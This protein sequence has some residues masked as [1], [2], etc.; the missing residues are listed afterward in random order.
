[1]V[2]WLF[3]GCLHP[4]GIGDCLLVLSLAYSGTHPSCPGLEPCV[5]RSLQRLDTSRN[6]MCRLC[7]LLCLQWRTP[8]NFIHT[9]GKTEWLWNQLSSHLCVCYFQSR[10]AP[11]AGKLK[12]L[13]LHLA[14]QWRPVVAASHSIPAVYALFNPLSK[15]WYVGQSTSIFHRWS[16]H[17]TSAFSRAGGTSGH[18]RV[19]C[20]MARL[21]PQLWCIFPIAL[22]CAES[23]YVSEQRLIKTLQPSEN[24]RSTARCGG[25]ARHR[26]PCKER[27]GSHQFRPL[28]LLPSVTNAVVQYSGHS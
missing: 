17:R 13:L 3:P 12:Q 24:S 10:T 8:H 22:V 1:M 23:L 27:R 2:D 16:Q 15:Q 4:L 25:N 26:P 19:H 20:T 7:A 9:G 6:D 11:P 28:R 21:G 5:L 14:P 18:Q